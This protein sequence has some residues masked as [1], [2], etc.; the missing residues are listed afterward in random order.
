MKEVENILRILKETESAIKSGKISLLKSLSDQTIH[1]ASTTQDEENI[2]VAV[3]VY[4]LGKIF[5]RQDYKNLK[6]WDKFEREILTSL[7]FSIEDL[8]ENKQ[9]KFK[10]DFLKIKNTI[11]KI[12][13]KLKKY[14][15]EVFQKAQV[16]KASRI[17]EHGI[18]L[19]KTSNLLGI[20][21]FDLA[22]Y[23]GQTGISEVNLNKTVGV[24]QRI[25]FLQEVFK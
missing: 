7:R 15:E 5:Q 14:V 2:A 16:H 18:S 22:N 13:G 8:E 3:I 24:K 20:S 23:T 21:M 12:S 11:N 19:E 4:S 25:K 10:E 17:H 9:D 6:G 1:T